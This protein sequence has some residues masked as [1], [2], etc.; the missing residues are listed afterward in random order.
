MEYSSIIRVLI[1]A[2]R[3]YCDVGL[4][5]STISLLLQA[6][7]EMTFVAKGYSNAEAASPAVGGGDPAAVESAMATPEVPAGEPDMTV[8]TRVKGP[9]PG[10]EI[11]ICCRACP[12]LSS[13]LRWTTSRLGR[14]RVAVGA[15]VSPYVAEFLVFLQVQTVLTRPA[16][17]APGSVMPVAA[18][19]DAALPR[20]RCARDRVTADAVLGRP[21]LF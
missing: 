20:E 6:S 5:A 15:L 7:F 9:E 18:A 1:V 11:D 16:A 10:E 21:R 14:S 17:P 12:T 19:L 2:K 3:R 4:T 13:C 8:V